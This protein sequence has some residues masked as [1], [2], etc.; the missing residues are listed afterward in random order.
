MSRSTD[1]RVIPLST[2]PSRT[3]DR[4][5]DAAIRVLGTNPSASMSAVALASG[6]GRATVYRYFATRDA[7]V[8]AILVR[9]LR[10]CREALAP[11]PLEMAPAGEALAAVVG[12]L[13]PVLDRYRVLVD[14]PPP[15]RSDP[16]QRAL[17]DAIE[18]PLLELIRRGQ[19]AGELDAGLPP[20]LVLGVLTGVLRA[21]RAA[22]AA[23]E[24]APERAHALAVRALLT[25]I[26]T[27][28]PPVSGPSATG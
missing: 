5:V 26:G 1:I 11:A 2:A 20:G 23:G 16:E 10:D 25:G 4:I 15:D 14:A 24:I 6:V 18:R 9:A 19:A 13:L 3:R 28:E 17:A 22:I 21:T 8:R 27:G 7:L 12:T